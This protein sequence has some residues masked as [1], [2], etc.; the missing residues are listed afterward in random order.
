M[1]SS[2]VGALYNN[3]PRGLEHLSYFVWILSP[4]DALYRE[5]LSNVYIEEEEYVEAAKCLVG[6]NLESGGLK[7]TDEE[8]AGKYVKIA[9]LYLQVC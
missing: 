1:A 2:C 6:I 5:C 7:F 3:F 8:K 4:Q 9:E